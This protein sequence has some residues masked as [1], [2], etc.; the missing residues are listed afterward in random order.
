M[1]IGDLSFLPHLWLLL[2]LRLLLYRA[3]MITITW[4]SLGSRFLPLFT[5]EN[6]GQ[7]HLAGLMETMGTADDENLDFRRLEKGMSKF[8]F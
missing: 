1:V 7:C 3:S 4:L 2:L 8:V 5:R 6:C